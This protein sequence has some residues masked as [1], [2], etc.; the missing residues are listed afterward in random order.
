M[1]VTYTSGNWLV[2]DGSGRAF[3]DQWTQVADWCLENADG[4]RFFRLIQDRANPR[5]FVSF[6]EWDDFDSLTVARSR[7]EFIRLF[8]GCQALCDEFS[9]SDY[10]VALA[11]PSPT[12]PAGEQR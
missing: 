2:R 1:D 7:P 4:A 3:I 9:G 11:V 10:T 6:G 8:R 12:P 5:H